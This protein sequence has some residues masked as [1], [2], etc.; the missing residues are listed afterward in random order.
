MSKNQFHFRV[1]VA[2]L[3][4]GILFVNSAF[5]AGDNCKNVKI[6]ISNSTPDEVKVTSFEY[7]DYD[8]N[9]WRTENMLG[10]DGIQ[11]LDASKGLTWTRDL[12]HVSNDN[13][14]FK[15]T[16]EHHIGGV[17]W[18]AALSATTSEFKCTEGL[19]KTVVLTQ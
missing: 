13:T 17:R 9:T 7:F 16:Y 10:I 15:V 4:L 2:A 12:E 8:R 5:A 14:K 18:G 3:G 19:A 6:T 11:K 1:S